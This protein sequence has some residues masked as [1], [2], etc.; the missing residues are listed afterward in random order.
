[1]AGLITNSLFENLA[2]DRLSVSRV[3]QKRPTS[4]LPLVAANEYNSGH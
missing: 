2:P 1:M 3:A 4:Q